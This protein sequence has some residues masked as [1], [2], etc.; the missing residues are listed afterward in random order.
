MTDATKRALRIFG[1]RLGNCMYDKDFLRE[2]HRASIQRPAHVSDGAHLT[3]NAKGAPSPPSATSTVPHKPP[4]QVLQK[5][6]SAVPLKI[7]RRDPRSQAVG[8]IDAPSAPAV[9]DPRPPPPIHNFTAA[10]TYQH[11]ICV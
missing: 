5:A 1:N 2:V 8:R 4:V 6:P 9:M 7:E 10:G 11:P 3:H